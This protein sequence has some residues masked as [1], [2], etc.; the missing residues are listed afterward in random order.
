M[1]TVRTPPSFKRF[2]ACLLPLNNCEGE[3][4][5]SGL[6]FEGPENWLDLACTCA[7]CSPETSNL[8]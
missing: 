7:D 3:E 6:H 8:S 5:E 2:N 4:S 1:K